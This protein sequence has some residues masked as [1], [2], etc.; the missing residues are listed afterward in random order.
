M[1][2]AGLGCAIVENF[3]MN[4]EGWYNVYRLPH[5]AWISN[6]Y[7]VRRKRKYISPQAL[8]FIKSILYGAQGSRH[9][10]GIIS[11]QGYCPGLAAYGP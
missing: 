3:E 11:I 7:I 8:A 5:A 1:V 2:R 9:I 10:Q 4:N 6:Y